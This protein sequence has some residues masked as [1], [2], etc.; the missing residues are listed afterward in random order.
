[1]D[2]GHDNLVLALVVRLALA[3]AKC[4]G[5]RVAVGQELEAATLDDLGD[6]LI[7]FKGGCWCTLDTDRQISGL[8]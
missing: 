8:V 3:N 4:Y 5:I 2:I 6:T 7:K 1:M